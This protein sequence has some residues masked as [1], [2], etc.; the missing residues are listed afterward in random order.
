[1]SIEEAEYILNEAVIDHPSIRGYNY[2][3]AEDINAAIEKILEE[4]M[5]EKIKLEELEKEI[6]E[7]R[8]NLK[9]IIKEKEREIEELKKQKYKSTH[10]KNVI[11]YIKKVVRPLF[12]L[13]S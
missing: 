13:E 5:K 2:I 10:I 7:E 12:L 4:K 6:I 11:K 8:N 1:M 9:N 3:S